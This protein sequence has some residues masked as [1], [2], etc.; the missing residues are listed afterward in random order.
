MIEQRLRQWAEAT[1]QGEWLIVVAH[2]F[3]FDA[4][5][6]TNQM[7][8]EG[9][10][11]LLIVCSAAVLPSYSLTSPAHQVAN[12]LRCPVHASQSAV[13]IDAGAQPFVGDFVKVEPD[14]DITSML[15]NLSI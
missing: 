9:T 15:G 2:D 8:V 1:L 10:Q 11:V 3:Q 4:S 5:Q 7:E 6:L 14:S 13:W 12:M